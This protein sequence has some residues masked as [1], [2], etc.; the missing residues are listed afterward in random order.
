MKCDII[1]NGIVAASR[2]LG[3]H[4]PLVVL[5]EG[6]NVEEGKRILKESELNI[7]SAD[8][9]AQGATAI[10]KAVAVRGVK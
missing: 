4:V 7:V 2:E 6:T 3:V 10:V 9:L 8:S 1:A 5:L